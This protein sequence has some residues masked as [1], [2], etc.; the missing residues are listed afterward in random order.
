MTW[1]TTGRVLGSLGVHEHW[2]NPI[3]RQ[4]SRD[5]GTGEGIELIQSLAVDVVPGNLEPDGDVDLG[6]LSVLLSHWLESN[7]T[8]CIGDL[9][10]DRDVDPEDLALF[11][12]NWGMRE[13]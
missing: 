12:Q 4:Y 11:A 3:D 9:D 13:L 6:D 1:R 10:G 8:G 7:Q 5:L 2:N